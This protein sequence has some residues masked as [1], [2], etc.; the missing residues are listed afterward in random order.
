MLRTHERNHGAIERGGGGLTPIFA[1]TYT[2]KRNVSSAPHFASSFQ[3][4][5][6][7]ESAGRLAQLVRAPAPDILP[8]VATRFFFRNLA[9]SSDGS[10]PLTYSC[11]PSA[12]APLVH[13]DVPPETQAA[14]DP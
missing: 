9:K 2:Q 11:F 13:Y 7:C 12:R 6:E 1:L 4:D 5:L 14:I 8:R 3:Q 10:F